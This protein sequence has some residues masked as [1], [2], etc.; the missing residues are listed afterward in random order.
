[1]RLLG[2]GH[3]KT[4]QK[5]LKYI[6]AYG[7]FTEQNSVLTRNIIDAHDQSILLANT[8]ALVFTE[9]ERDD[10]D[11]GN[12]D[13]SL[14]ECVAPCMDDQGFGCKQTRASGGCLHY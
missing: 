7:V 3:Q 8:S 6:F 12:G 9:S 14:P 4:C 10:S 11:G 5:N 2:Y 13:D 1:V